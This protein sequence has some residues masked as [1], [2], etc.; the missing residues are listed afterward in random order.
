[1]IRPDE[2]AQSVLA[3]L[4]LQSIY[5]LLLF[6]LVWGMVKCCR[7]RYP[8]WQ[9]C[10]WFLILMRL[11]LPPDMAMPWSAS[12]LIRSLTPET[13]NRNFLS[14]PYESL[15]FQDSNK[16]LAPSLFNELTIDGHNPSESDPTIGT[17]HAVFPL[18]TPMKRPYLILC[19]AY[20]TVVILLLVLFLRTRR[21]FWKIARQGKTVRD[22]AVLYIIR[23]WRRRLH[24]S[25]EI[26]VKAIVSDVPTYT[27]GL[28]R[29]VV[30]L[31][32]HLIYSAESAALESV[33]AH[34]LMHVKRWDD[35]AICLQ[36]LVRIVY[37]F[38]P[39]VWFVI[40]RLTWTREA[41]C[42]V[43]VLSHGTLSPR[44]YGRQVLAF[45]RGQTFPKEPPKGLAKFTSA[46]KGMAFRLNHIQKED[47]MGSHP[48]LIYITVLILGLF[49]LPM[50]PVASSG[51]GKTA[52]SVSVLVSQL[53]DQSHRQFADNTLIQ[54]IVQ[55]VPCQ[56]PEEITRIIWGDR[57]KED[58]REEDFSR[59]VAATDFD[60]VENIGDGRK[61]YVFY[62]LSDARQG[63]YRPNFHF[64]MRQGKLNLIF[65]SR[66]LSTYVTDRSK[67]NG[68][69]EI[70]EGWRADLFDGIN[71]DRVNLAWGSTVWFWAG[72]KYVKAYTDYIIA[73]A[74]DPSLLGTR[75][76]WEKETRPVYEAAR[77]K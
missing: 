54:Y 65:K 34:E 42:D 19:G 17:K 55:R 31:P 18:P 11:V 39:L 60:I 75:R 15:T 56:N 68:H 44:A 59:L 25:R 20:L 72:N 57:I 4:S 27:M 8:R 51:Q 63:L 70:I 33:L 5:A 24:I 46:A 9:H 52:E 3:I 32:E 49:L 28:F 38:H 61:A 1:M 43:T 53:R 14:I 21:R 13:V 37:F 6:P 35:L 74:T 16:P 66:K 64:I 10:L 26:E 50:A 69:Y 41:V 45:D 30:I 22:P 76:E 36:E 12:H 7:G 47:N 73:E 40:P 71:D 29:P 58:F 67:V 77:K 2:I 23:T 62:L 48:L